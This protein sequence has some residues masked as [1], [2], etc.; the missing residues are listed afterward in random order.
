MEKEVSLYKLIYNKIV[1]RILI[2]MY[3][4]GFQLSS[5][6]KIRDEFGIG[7]TSI[8]RAMRLFPANGGTKAPGG[9][10]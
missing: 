10:F 4:K 5:M 2:G 3:P 8:R 1:N 9:D 7:L 6:E